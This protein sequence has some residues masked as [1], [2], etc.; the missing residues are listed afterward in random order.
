MLTVAYLGLGANLGDPIQQLLDARDALRCHGSTESLRCSS[1]YVSSPVGDKQQADFINCVVEVQTRC[2]ALEL[3][4]CLQS[5]ENALGRQRVVGNQNAPRRIDLD[6]LLFGD[7]NIDSQRL[8]VPHPRMRDRL[9]V[10]E[11]LLELAEIDTYRLVMDEYDF[12]GQTLSRLAIN[13]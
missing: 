13:A 4:D 3:L 9:F 2:N 8:T 6:M 5:I 7:Q 1:F 11:P 12:A 10:I